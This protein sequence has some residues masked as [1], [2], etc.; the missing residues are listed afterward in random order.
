[1]TKK[2]KQT[3]KEIDLLE[4]HISDCIKYSKDINYHYRS[5]VYNELSRLYKRLDKIK[6][7]KKRKEA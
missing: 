5:Q 1:M 4:S 2:E 7:T 3:L 6:Y